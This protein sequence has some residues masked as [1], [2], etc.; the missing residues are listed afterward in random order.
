MS[1]LWIPFAILLLFGFVVWL[2]ADA[3]YQPPSNGPGG[4][5]ES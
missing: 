5:E 3:Q 4:D 2:L 1:H